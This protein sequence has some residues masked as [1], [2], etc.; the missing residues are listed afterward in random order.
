M[1]EQIAQRF[2]H[3]ASSQPSESEGRF[4]DSFNNLFRLLLAQL[5]AFFLGSL[6]ARKSSF[7]FP[8]DLVELCDQAS[9][10]RNGCWWILGVFEELL[11]N[12]VDR[13]PEIG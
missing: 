5:K 6:I 10:L 7:N 2:T 13:D 8:F 4:S 11:S 12:V 3:G 1:G 9:D